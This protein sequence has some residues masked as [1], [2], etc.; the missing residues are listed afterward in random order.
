[1]DAETLALGTMIATSK[2]FKRDLIDEAWNRYTFEDKNLPDW[3]V[4]D[5]KKH[6][7]KSMAIPEVVKEVVEVYVLRIKNKNRN[8]TLKKFNISDVLFK[9]YILITG[10]WSTPKK[11]LFCTV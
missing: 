8:S 4:E 7:Q 3:F 1:M 2:K 10:N 5:E 9:E 6:M 11:Y